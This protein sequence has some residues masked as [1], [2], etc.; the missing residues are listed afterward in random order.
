MAP[1][2]PRGSAAVALSGDLYVLRV[3]SEGRRA[4][5]TGATNVTR[6]MAAPA[7]WRAERLREVWLLGYADGLTGVATEAVHAVFEHQANECGQWG[8]H[9]ALP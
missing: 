9:E 5:W 7:V 6:R 1:S 2:C 8:A 4:R 3:V